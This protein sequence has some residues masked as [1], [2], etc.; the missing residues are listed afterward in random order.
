MDKDNYV[1]Y[2]DSLIQNLKN[3]KLKLA[4]EDT[5]KVKGIIQ[6]I[7]ERVPFNSVGK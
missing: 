7:D 4:I 5:D 6:K 1:K 2:M 3:M